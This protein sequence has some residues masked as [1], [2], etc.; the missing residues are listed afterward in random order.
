M[1]A[2]ELSQLHSVSE[3]ELFGHL[4]HL[5]T[6]FGKRFIVNPSECR[7]CGFVFRQDKHIKKPSKCPSC[8]GTWLSDPSFFLKS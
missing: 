5:R 4:E 2:R 1:T 8:K 7:K 6:T 3:K